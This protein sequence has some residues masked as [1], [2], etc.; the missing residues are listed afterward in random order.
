MQG[1]AAFGRVVTGMDVVR[2]INSLPADAPT[3]SEYTRGQ[4]LSSP[5]A[6]TKVRRA[7]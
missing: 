4:I 7:D 5:A 1:F 6:I 2:K 3:E